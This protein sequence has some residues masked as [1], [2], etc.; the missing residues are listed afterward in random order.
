MLNMKLEIYIPLKIENIAKFETK[1]NLHI[2]E[3]LTK[4]F[5]GCT[6]I[7][8]NGTWLNPKTKL[9]EYDNI[10]IVRI[11]CEK[12]F[13]KNNKNAQKTFWNAIITLKEKL[14]QNCIAYTINDNDKMEFY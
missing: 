12:G 2:I 1:N 7:K 9:M 3:D 4:T 6:L 14:N 8:A 5:G 11:Y 10:T 13:W